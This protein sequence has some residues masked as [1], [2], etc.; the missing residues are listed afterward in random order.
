[1]SLIGN[2]FGWCGW[3]IAI[4]VELLLL[5][6][7]YRHLFNCDYLRGGSHTLVDGCV[8]HRFVVGVVYSSLRSPSL[9]RATTCRALVFILRLRGTT[10]KALEPA[11]RSGPLGCWCYLLS[12]GHSILLS[13]LR[14]G[15]SS[16]IHILE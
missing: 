3:S 10:P 5:V 7:A 13:Q 11:L 14:C 6:R 12:Y 8:V 2:L 16:M 4:L 1:M 15:R 9:D